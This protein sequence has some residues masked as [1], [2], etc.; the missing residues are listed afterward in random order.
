MDVDGTL[1]CSDL[2]WE[3]VASLVKQRP[4]LALLLP[5]WLLKGK[6]YLKRRLTGLVSIDAA[7]LPYNLA[8]IE[9]LRQEKAR[10]RRLVLV[11]ASDQ[12]WADAIAAHLG[13]FDEVMGSD[14]TINLRGEA[15]A[16]S[17]VARFGAGKFDY[18][19]DAKPDLA[20]WAQA[21]QA[22]L[23]GAG[24]RVTAE[25]RKRFVV[26]AEFPRT[27]SLPQAVF[28]LLRP[29]QWVKNLLVFI[30]L[31]TSHQIAQPAIAG[32]ALRACLALCLC[33]SSIYV[34]NDFLDL[35]ADRRH[36]R[37]RRRPLASGAVPLVL[38]LPLSATLFVAAF[39]VAASISPSFV[40]T[41]IV[42]AVTSSAYSWRL[43]QIAL[44]DVFILAGL[45][46]L[47]VIAG[48][49]ATAVEYSDWLLAFS[50]FIF[51]SL[52]L[53]KRF[54]ELQQQTKNGPSLIHGRGY[55]RE[56]LLLLTPLGV[57]SGYLAVLVL[58]LYVNSAQVRIL[59]QRPTIL[60]LACPL[61]LYWISRVW[62]IA[63]HG[64]MH[65]DPVAFAL[66]DSVSYVIGGLSLAIVWAA[67]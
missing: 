27:H 62:M 63:H 1:I 31:I 65:D 43:K 64:R 38:A 12:I 50:M 11:T 61:L 4:L 40:A 44:L 60:L 36:P 34:T 46:T 54:Q 45:Y 29:H 66:K 37:K 6:A 16:T 15:K 17:L 67:T 9:F 57:A 25:A 7:N 20:V 26:A 42:Y 33:A 59:Y 14:G 19:G 55:D 56:D 23:V 24:R 52:A 22:V 5:W 47:R 39:G 30:P 32:A 13:F 41:L 49:T 58:A 51:L 28:R 3:S 2:L 35:A 48:H 53:V 18:A 8:L 21:R 10:G